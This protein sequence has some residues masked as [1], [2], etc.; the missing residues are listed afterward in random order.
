MIQTM[1]VLAGGFAALV[2]IALVRKVRASHM[3]PPLSP[4][5]LTRINAEYSELPQ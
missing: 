5:V 2:M 3:P 1:M 4:D